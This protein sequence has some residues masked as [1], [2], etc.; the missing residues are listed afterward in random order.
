MRR[1]FYLIIL[2]ILVLPYEIHAQK[3]GILNREKSDKID[4]LLNLYDSFE[5]LSGVVLVAQDGKIIYK[6]GF[7]EANQEWKIKN[8]SDTKFQIGSLTKQFTAAIILQL[9]EEGKLKVRHNIS[10]YLPHYRKDIGEKV[11]IHQLLNHTSGIPSFTNRPDFISTIIRSYIPIKEL[12]KEYCSN[13]LEFIP[14]EEFKYNNSGYIILAAIIEATTG[15]SYEEN[16]KKR[17]LDPLKMT[18]SGYDSPY[19]VLEKRASGYQKIGFKYINA[20]FIDMS[21]P[22]AASGMYSTVDDL[23]KWD[24]ALKGNEILSRKAKRKMFSPELGNYGYGWYIEDTQTNING[25]ETLKAYHTGSVPGFISLN[26]KLI[27]DNHSVIILAN[28]DV[29]PILEIGDK[30]VATLYDL[31]YDLPRKP[32]IPMMLQ[33]IEKQGIEIAIGEYKRLKSTQRGLWKIRVGELNYLGKEL[34]K[35]DKMEEALIIFKLNIEEFPQSDIP[36]ES[37]A[38]YY[39]RNGNKTKALEYYQKALEINPYNERVA[40]R[41]KIWR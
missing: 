34:I 30:L 28:S 20:M 5:A 9:E 16:L 12:V 18:D 31:P 13:D 3:I 35:L 19:T 11:T 7:G 40:R 32:I 27:E 6:K 22:N 17:I 15:M 21:I 1:V 33:S 39:E 25:S 29:V 38:S 36:Y 24:K 8:T 26:I 37:L 10:D 4:R 23:F 2:M 41:I 14:G